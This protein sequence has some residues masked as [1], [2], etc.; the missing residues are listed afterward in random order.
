[1]GVS[2]P[3]GE[4]QNREALFAELALYASPFV[5]QILIQSDG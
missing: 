1:M 3:K 2:N 4:G 5:V